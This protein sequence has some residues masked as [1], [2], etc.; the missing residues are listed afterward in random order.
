MSTRIPYTFTVL[1]YVHDINAGEFINVGV[2]VASPENG[3]IKAKFKPSY[4]RLKKTFPTLNGE[5]FRKRIKALQS[6]FDALQ[7]KCS[8]ELPLTSGGRIQELIHSILPKD[9]SALQWSPIGSGLSSDLNETLSARYARL[10]AK[11]DE[12]TTSERRKDDDIW[13]DFKTSLEKHHLTKY[14]SP[15]TIESLNDDV[16]FEH[17]WK[18]GAWHCY[19][20]LSFDL[21]SATSI[22]DKAHRWLGQL[23]SVQ[24]DATEDFKVYFLLGKPCDE[25][26]QPAYQ[27]ARSILLKAPDVELVEESEAEVFSQ[28]VAVAIALHN[29]LHPL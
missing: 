9:D 13:R 24:E 20:P 16:R 7:T 2:V 12:V 3:F 8:E 10:V 1:R 29:E 18:N 28:K 27:Q 26:L 22:K 17:A 6:S 14:L 11:Y 4:G 21:S 25:D 5:D 15:K 23:A 19:E